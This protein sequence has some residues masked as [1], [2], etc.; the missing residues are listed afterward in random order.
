MDVELRMIEGKPVLRFERELRHSPEKVWRVVTDPAE[1]RHWFPA[2][3]EVDGRKMRF[4]FP[5][6]APVDAD[7]GEGEVLECDPPRVFAFRWIDDVLRF[8]VLPRDQGCL[9]VFTAVVTTRLTA[10]RDAPGWITCLDALVAHV[11][12][13]EFQAPRDWLARIEHYVREFGLDEGTDGPGGVRFVRD[14]VWTP[15]DDVW[16]VLT[17]GS[18]DGVPTRAAHPGLEPGRVVRSDAPR[19]LEYEWLQDGEPRG[20]VRWEFDHV[21]LQG[22][23]VTLL[24]ENAHGPEALAAWHVHLELFFAATQGEI[25]CPWPS[26]REEELRRR[27]A[28]S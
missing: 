26:D 3:V 7:G 10:G 20:V 1:M 9:L 12:G 21:P 18:E 4:T 11:D 24:Q 2:E 15:L 16:Q 19:L 23:T 13:V 17:E 8:E 27:Y 28:G 25:R 6:A 22:T 14:L 5:E